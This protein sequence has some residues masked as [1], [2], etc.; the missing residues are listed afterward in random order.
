MLQIYYTF[1]LCCS[2]L[3]ESETFFIQNAKQPSAT[4]IDVAQIPTQ[5]WSKVVTQPGDGANFPNAGDTVNM[6]VNIH[7][8]PNCFSI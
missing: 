1:L 7:I 4:P 2:A 5:G 6:D 3:R 8:F